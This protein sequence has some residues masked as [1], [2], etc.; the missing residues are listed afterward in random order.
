MQTQIIKLCE[1][2]CGKQAPI[3]K[4][5]RTD[6]GPRQGEPVRFIYGHSTR[7]LKR[8]GPMNSHWKGGVTT[9][10]G[11]LMTL[12]R[13]HHRA[14]Q[15]GY[16]RVHLLI[17]EQV[18]GGPLPEFAEVHHVNKIRSDNRNCNLVICDSRAY[19]ILLHQRERAIRAG[20]AAHWRKCV[21]CK[22]YDDPINLRIPAVKRTSA[23][24]RSCA[25]S[26]ALRN[27]HL[28]KGRPD[29]QKLKTTT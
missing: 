3:A 19:H 28:R 8:N 5:T 14:D 29:G 20:Y 1:C 13:G 11:Y 25:A 15:Y 10:G 21:Y 23:Y 17:V 6:R 18:L 24:H 9:N 22:T 16:V 12:Q 7:V 4:C 26:V 27:Y 2:G